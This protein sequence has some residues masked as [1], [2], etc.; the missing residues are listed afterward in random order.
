MGLRGKTFK[1]LAASSLALVSIAG[2]IP[3][4]NKSWNE[5]QPDGTTLEVTNFGNEHFHY[6]GT[7]D[8]YPL[9]RDS[10]GFFRFIDENGKHVSKRPSHKDKAIRFLKKKFERDQSTPILRA[11][12]ENETVES[13]ESAAGPLKQSAAKASPYSGEKNVLV[14]LVQF[15]DTKFFSE[16]PQAVF[17]DMLNTEGYNADGNIGSARDYLLENSMGNFSPHLTLSAPSPS[18]ATTTRITALTPNSRIMAPRSPSWKPWILSLQKALISASTT[19][20]AT[21]TWILST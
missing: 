10:L 20:M 8:G 5:K 11:P 2:A 14:I 16:D 12:S 1:L 4:L 19:T 18:A 6:T 15:K 9:H 7:T 21:V 3:P 13:T 17:D